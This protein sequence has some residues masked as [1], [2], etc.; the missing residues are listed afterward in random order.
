MRLHRVSTFSAAALLAA[1]AGS[2][3]VPAGYPPVKA[4][5]YEGAQRP[6]A[7]VA[8][9]FIVDGRPHYEAGFICGID[10]GKYGPASGRCASMAY[11]LPGM[12][13]F[14]IVYQSPRYE[15]CTV[16]LPIRAEA[17]HLY[18][19]N[20]T[21]FSIQRVCRVSQ[22][23]MADGLKA[24]YRNVAPGQAPAALLDQPIPY[25]LP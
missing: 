25:G 7:E 5:G 17:G 4:Q 10:G 21:G 6:E 3:L 18:Q 23:P 20:A 19:L 11:V 13:T 1:C 8:T 2:G 14:S 9:V 24:T 12:H 16:D 22:I 15:T